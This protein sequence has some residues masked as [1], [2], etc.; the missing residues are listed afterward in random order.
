MKQA[1]IE[2]GHSLYPAQRN[3]IYRGPSVTTGPWPDV[4]V[5]ESEPGDTTIRDHR[6]RTST[7]RTKV[8][9]KSF[10]PTI[11]SATQ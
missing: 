1:N 11:R 10:V 8:F 9:T 5:I 4:V 2:N 7:M 6:G 3:R